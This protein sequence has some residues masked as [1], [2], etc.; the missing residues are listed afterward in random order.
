MTMTAF[1]AR[2]RA[3]GIFALFGLVVVLLAAGAIGA[4]VREA[5]TLDAGV[6]GGAAAS[7]PPSAG[8]TAAPPAQTQ[9]PTTTPTTTPT[10]TPTPTPTATSAAQGTAL[11]QLET[12]AVKGRAP[13]TGYDRE[14]QFGRA[15][16][17]V[18]RNGC[19]TRNDMLTRDLTVTSRDGCRVLTGI[20]L[21]PYT[22]DTI[23]FLRG[24]T[25]SAEV[26]I[27]HV[28][29]LMNAWQSGAQQL[30]DAQRKALANDPVNLLAVGGSVN[31]RKGDGDAATWLPPQR[32]VWCEYIAR[33]ITVKAEYR[34]WTTQAEH[35]AMA[36]VL[37]RCP[38]QQAY[39]SAL[40]ETV[41]LGAP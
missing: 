15:W 32:A 36:R 29:A 1:L 22:G 8:Q 35:D 40:A 30:D 39:D 21:D 16:I 27:D 18:D 37:T 10:P 11:A 5:G 14:G 31:A 9:T 28:V 41:G 19:D 20:L 6:G 38:E 25:T 24:Q 23:S 17:D 3:L 34:L 26:Q 2:A 7:G 12:L 4:A 13:K 33:Q